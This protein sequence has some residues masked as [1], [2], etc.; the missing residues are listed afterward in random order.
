MR[1][2]Q[3][4]GAIMVV[5]LAGCGTATALPVT[6]HGKGHHGGPPSGTRSASLRLA[7][8]LMARD[9]LPP[10]ARG[11]PQHPV[12]PGLRQ[13]PGQI[14]VKTLADIYRLFAV[15]ASMRQTAAY[16]GKHAPAGMTS[17]GTG[18]IGGR[19]G[20]TEMDVE[21]FLNRTP[22]GVSSA[23]LIDTIV[24]APHGGA[25]LRVDA[26]VIWY[27]PR[28]AAE[29]LVAKDFR[30]VRIDAWLALSGRHVRR[31]FTSRGVI[32]RLTRVLNSLPASPGGLFPCPL[33]I[34]SYRLTF[35]PVAGHPE[36]VVNTAGCTS[37]T[38]SVGGVTQPA[39]VD[40]GQFGTLVGKIMHIH[41]SLARPGPRSARPA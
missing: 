17:G 24:P 26:Q 7:R 34:V 38:I 32:G 10:G 22:R 29:Y 19:H 14:G 36:A 41:P 21:Y 6:G 30:A 37:D 5:A 33:E 1:L 27:P 4:A 2:R 15:P 31:T 13:V 8:Q 11:L 20:V 16:I 3:V 40:S 25:L 23:D 12:P 39:L 28:S 35:E 9:P 18:Q